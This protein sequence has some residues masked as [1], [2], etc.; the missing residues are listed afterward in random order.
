MS[1]LLK[2]VSGFSETNNSAEPKLYYEYKSGHKEDVLVIDSRWLTSAEYE[3]LCAQGVLL[4]PELLTRSAVSALYPTIDSIDIH[5]VCF[6]CKM[7]ERC[8]YLLE[9]VWNTKEVVM[10]SNCS[11]SNTRSVNYMF[12]G[13]KKLISINMGNVDMASVVSAKRMFRGCK[14]LEEITPLS[15]WNLISLE[16][17]CQMFHGC[18][19]LFSKFEIRSK[20]MPKL[21]NAYGMFCGTGITTIEM[22]DE[23]YPE[24]ES[25][26]CM[27]SGCESLTSL[28][29]NGLN[30]PKL[31]DATQM[32][33]YCP[34][35]SRPIIRNWKADVLTNITAMFSECYSLDC[36]YDFELFSENVEEYER[37]FSRT[38]LEYLD[39]SKWTI[40]KLVQPDA[41]W[42]NMCD[43]SKVKLPCSSIELANSLDYL[44]SIP[45]ALD[46]DNRVSGVLYKCMGEVPVE[47]PYVTVKRVIAKFDTRLLGTIPWKDS[48]KGGV[49]FH[50]YT[51]RLE[52]SKSF[53]DYNTALYI[54][55]CFTKGS[56][57][58]CLCSPDVTDNDA[59]EICNSLLWDVH[60]PEDIALALMGPKVVGVSFK[61]IDLIT[62]E[63]HLTIDASKVT[64]GFNK[65]IVKLLYQLYKLRIDTSNLNQ[66]SYD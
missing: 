63:Y 53:S 38:R 3:R 64:P 50:K 29:I 44:F 33:S 48:I 15:E 54:S 45:V 36:I 37:M 4:H 18:E 55:D 31:N 23:V 46:G 27:F 52:L 19:K 32:F 26:V 40:K 47:L 58:V 39:L 56:D 35:L 1:D 2:M 51:E 28:Y 24:L 14:Q 11:F 21:R 41:F 8:S 9:H 17:A 12:E 10:L 30:T 20:D 5:T 49:D 43:P 6:N 57:F 22:V 60:M 66:V 65:E 7:P 59:F 16:N 25:A 34:K 62:Q 13:A 61:Q 42:L